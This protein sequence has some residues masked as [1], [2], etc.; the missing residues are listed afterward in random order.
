VRNVLKK[1]LYLPILPLVLLWRAISWPFHAFFRKPKPAKIEVSLSPEE[2]MDLYAKGERTRN[3]IEIL[4][5]L[6]PEGMEDP[7]RQRT[8]TSYRPY[9]IDCDSYS[10]QKYVKEHGKAQV[11]VRSWSR[12]PIYRRKVKNNWRWRLGVPSMKEQGASDG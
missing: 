7:R 2:E 12:G 5:D 4:A 1:L 10:Y 6:V 11:D 9:A 3:V 8:S